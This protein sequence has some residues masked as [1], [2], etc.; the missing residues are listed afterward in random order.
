MVEISQW[1]VTALEEL[2]G[3]ALS[4]SSLQKWQTGVA[5]IL[6]FSRFVGAT[7]HAAS[8]TRFFSNSSEPRP[9]I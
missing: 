3:T 5:T 7:V 1:L 9:Y 2:S 6:W 4:V 8:N